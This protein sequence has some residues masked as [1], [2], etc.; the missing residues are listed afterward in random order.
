MINAFRKGL[1]DT[2]ARFQVMIRKEIIAALRIKSRYQWYNRRDGK[3]DHTP[4]ERAAIEA[5]F[6]KYDVTSPWGYE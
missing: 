1:G 6:A 5:V 4:A 2:Q 3:V